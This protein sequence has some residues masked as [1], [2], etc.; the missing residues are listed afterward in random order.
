MRRGLF[1]GQIVVYTA[2]AIGVGFLLT[3][4]VGEPFLSMTELDVEEYLDHAANLRGNRYTFEATIA[5]ALAWTPD[6]GRLFS[7]DVP[8]ADNDVAVLPVLI[9][10]ALN[11]RNVQKGQVYQFSVDIVDGGLI[12]VKEMRKK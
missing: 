1:I 10:A 8:T 7:V 9:P 4:L 3:R 5:N 11:Q 6:R 2:I 12:Q